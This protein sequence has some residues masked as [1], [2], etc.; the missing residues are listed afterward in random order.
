M[1]APRLVAAALLTVLLLAAGAS[2]A[3]GQRAGCGA[4]VGSRALRRA[5]TLRSGNDAG[6]PRIYDSPLV[7]PAP[8]APLQVRACCRAQNVTHTLFLAT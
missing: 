5:V 1:R 8:V 7:T 4:D 3:A 6:D 2:R